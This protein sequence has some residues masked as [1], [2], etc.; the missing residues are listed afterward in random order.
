MLPTVYNC[1]EAASIMSLA[2]PGMT[3][4]IRLALGLMAS[5][6]L[7]A[8]ILYHSGVSVYR[9]AGRRGLRAGWVVAAVMATW[10]VGWLI[11]SLLAWRWPALDAS[12]TAPALDMATWFRA[13]WVGFFWFVAGMLTIGFAIAGILALFIRPP[14]EPHA[15]IFAGW[16]VSGL[17]TTLSYERVVFQRSWRMP[18]RMLA[19]G[20]GAVGLWAAFTD[21]STWSFYGKFASGGTAL[22]VTLSYLCQIGSWLIGG[23]SAVMLMAKYPGIGSGDTAPQASREVQSQVPQL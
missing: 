15:M 17:I 23:A 20:L 22:D 2:A 1:Y 3:S 21:G 19:M 13:S 10:P 5:L 14:T 7:M 8:L 6:T 4:D 12:D 18:A 16:F 9:D 11:Y